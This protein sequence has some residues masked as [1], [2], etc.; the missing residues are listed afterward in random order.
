VYAAN[1]PT[2]FLGGGGYLV[3]LSDSNPSWWGSVI[4]E[5]EVVPPEKLKTL[6]LDK[7]F[8][9][10]Y[11]YADDI[12]KYLTATLGFPRTM[13]DM[14]A[15]EL[16]NFPRQR[17]L[18]DF[19]NVIY[20]KHL[21]GSVAEGGVFRGTFAKL[22]NEYF[23]DRNLWLFDSFEAFNPIEVERDKQLGLLQ[24]NYSDIFLKGTSI[25]AVKN[26]LPHPEKAVFKQGF[27]PKSIIGDERFA[28]E[29][30]VFV[31]LD[32]DLYEPTLAGLDCFYPKMIKGGLILVHD[33]FSWSC[34]GASEAV[35]KWCAENGVLCVPIGDGMSVAIT[36]SE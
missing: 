1:S 2:P 15:A 3:A 5:V 4:D 31:N 21:E 32:F 14:V 10:N 30:F 9:S 17:F 11:Y 13:I 20:R 12:C 34:R 35:D 22:I 23:P 18:F 27:F 7:I 33:Y 36:K 24:K 29:K 8:I 25:G 16:I 19:A 28:T 6:S 26:V